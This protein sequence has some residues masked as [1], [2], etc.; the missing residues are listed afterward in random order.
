MGNTQEMSLPGRKRSRY[1]GPE[2]RRCLGLKELLPFYFTGLWMAKVRG[3]GERWGQS[4]EQGQAIKGN[5]L[6]LRVWTLC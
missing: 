6:R 1:R 2:T 4:S 3:S 5:V